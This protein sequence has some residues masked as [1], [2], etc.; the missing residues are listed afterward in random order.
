[1]QGR[2]ELGT[3]PSS[4]IGR[5]IDGAGPPNRPGATAEPCLR[6]AKPY[7]APANEECGIIADITIWSEIQ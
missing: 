2:A 1:M 6:V 7:R 5:W 4:D 3:H